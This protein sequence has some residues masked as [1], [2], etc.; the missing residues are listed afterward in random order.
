MKDIITRLVEGRNLSR[1]E[2]EAAMATIMDGKATPA[3]IG[4]FVTALR[5]KGETV[6]EITGF[7]AVMREKCALIAPRV[8]GPL[9]D[10]CGT[11]GAPVK[12]FNVSTISAFVAAGAGIAVAKHGNRAV[13]STCGSADVLETLGANL[14]LPPSEVQRVIE[15]VGVGF[16]FAP[17]FHP[18]MKHAAGPRREIGIRTVF[19]V[20]GPLT[21]PAGARHQVIGVYHASLVQKLTQVLANLGAERALVVHGEGGL[22]EISPLGPTRIGQVLDGRVSYYTVNPEELGFRRIGAADEV[23]G[24][25]KEASARVFLEVLANREGPRRDMVLANAAAA[26]FV[27]GKA[28]DIKSGLDVARES[29]ESGRALGKLRAYVEAT[30]GKFSG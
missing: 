12:T 13:T 27:G 20:L 1:A 2:A 24:L 7:A 8:A 11:G 21:N 15:E 3:Q 19:N 25:D 26:A 4:A 17:N 30:G 29:L 16:L 10:T 28:K 9:I 14:A 6:E 22:D 23:G 5:M 18:A